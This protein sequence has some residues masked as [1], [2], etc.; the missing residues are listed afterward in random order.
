MSVSPAGTMNQGGDCSFT[1]LSL[2]FSFL[3]KKAKHNTQ[4]LQKVSCYPVTG[5]ISQKRTSKKQGLVKLLLPLV[6]HTE[7]VITFYKNIKTF[8][9][10]LLMMGFSQSVIALQNHA[11]KITY[12]QQSKSI[13]L[14]YLLPFSDLN[15]CL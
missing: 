15:N 11:S 10:Y 4:P 5:E 9:S 1:R 3:K 8:R 2:F 12:Y 13:S 7:E 14:H 6:G